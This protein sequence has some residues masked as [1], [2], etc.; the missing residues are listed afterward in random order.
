MPPDVAL[1]IRSDAV[2]CVQDNSV[3]AKKKAFINVRTA[4][5]SMTPRFIVL[6]KATPYLSVTDAL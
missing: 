2:S 1:S 5:K 6:E 4:N 3:T